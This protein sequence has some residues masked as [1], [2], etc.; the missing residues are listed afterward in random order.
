M[1]A[2][3]YDD[4]EHLVHWKRGVWPKIH[5]KLFELVQEQA[6]GRRFCDLSCSTGLLGARLLQ[7]LRPPAEA[8]LGVECDADAVARARAAGVP[9]EFLEMAVNPQTLRAFGEALRSRRITVLVGRRCIPEICGEDVSF[10]RVLADQLLD[11]GVTEV[12]LEG[13][14][15]RATA[16]HPLATLQAE[17]K[18]LGPA[19]RT[20]TLRN[21]LAYLVPA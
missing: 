15:Q 5:A 4:Q 2:G 6:R 8:V 1:S 11:A 9:V 18:A 20:V 7:R 13:R 12:F 14:Q 21:D 16:T 10:G 17:I 3:R 19:W